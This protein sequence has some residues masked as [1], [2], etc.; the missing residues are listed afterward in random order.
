MLTELLIPTDHPSHS[1]DISR[2]PSAR[3]P[4]IRPPLASSAVMNVENSQQCLQQQQQPRQPQ[5][6]Q[7]PQQPPLQQQ[8]SYPSLSAASSQNSTSHFHRIRSL[9]SA[10]CATPTLSPLS[11]KSPKVCGKHSK[12]PRP[13]AGGG[14]AYAAYLKAWAQQA[15]QAAQKGHPGLPPPGR[16]VTKPRTSHGS[17]A[18]NSAPASRTSTPGGQTLRARAQMPPRQGGRP[19]MP[20]RVHGSRAYSAASRRMVAVE[21][22]PAGGARR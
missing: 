10:P 18:G 22:V 9:R 4:G 19:L 15:E 16:L 17:V 12:L 20:S 3:K 13:A 8:S 21:G 1:A 7:L 11:I 2:V 6:P 5:Q 14:R